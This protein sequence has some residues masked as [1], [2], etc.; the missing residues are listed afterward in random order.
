MPEDA[1][2]DMNASV[3]LGSGTEV[4]IPFCAEMSV[5]SDNRTRMSP[6]LFQTILF[7]RNNEFYWDAG[8]LGKA[9]SGVRNE[10]PNQTFKSISITYK[11]SSI[12]KL[13]MSKHCD[14][15]YWANTNYCRRICLNK[16]DL[17]KFSI[18]SL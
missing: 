8:L 13:S 12:R 11:T 5:I 17:I 3:V 4:D 1:D 2:G 18:G 14:D 16:E 7:L 10:K 9:N 6:Q 15:D